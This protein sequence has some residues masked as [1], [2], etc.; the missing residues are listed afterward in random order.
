MSE[1]KEI[2][3]KTDE[4][5]E[6]LT[7]VPK[8][9]VRWGVSIIFGIMML[10]L[11][12]SFFIKYPETLP[13]TATITTTNPPIT[14]VAKT[15]GKIILLPVKNN[16]T[17]KKGDVMMM[18]ENP[19]NYKHILTVAKLVDSFQTNLKLQKN[20]PEFLSF[21]TLSLG[22]IS[23]PFLQFLKS[24]NSYKLFTET[25]PQQKE[26]LI[27][28][29]EL[30][31]YSILLSKYQLQEQLSKQEF[32]LAEK[33][34]NR[35]KTLF[36]NGSISSKEFE[37][38]NKD[39]I[40]SKKNYENIKIN[41]LN[42][43]ITMSNLEKNKLQLQLLAVQESEKYLQELNE[44]IQRLKLQIDTWIQTYL[45]IAPFDGVVSL[46]NYW[47]VNQAIKQGD[48]VVSI[49]PSR[50]Q[51]VIGKLILP[52]QNSGKLKTG[53]VVNIKLNNYPYQEYGMLKGEVRNISL[54]P[55][56]QNYSIEV[57][58]PHQLETSYK[59]KLEYKEEMQ[60]TAEIVTEQLSLFNRIFYQFRKLMKK[61]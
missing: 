9:I 54:I 17:V 23:T 53:Q 25:N 19:G 42:N 33:D 5:N 56:K 46:F 8:W 18:F 37:D 55:Q 59:K 52:M 41:N 35:F 3:I 24:Y 45:I 14:L 43:R 29:K 50:K 48:E 30:E 31:T 34:F 39:Y 21:D 22:D 32:D 49:V 11:V 15:N 36:Q 38:K 16:Q 60:G 44:S 12:F 58:L 1:E 13:A 26:I 51:E 4:V 7:A 40:N 27:I 61:G 20:L 6:L 28:N 47:N 10:V 57:A 2:E